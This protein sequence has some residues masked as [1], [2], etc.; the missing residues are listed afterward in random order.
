MSNP[1]SHLV[2]HF[3]SQLQHKRDTTEA[4]LEQMHAQTVQQIQ[5]ALDRLYFEI[6]AKMRELAATQEDGEPAKIPLSWLHEDNRLEQIKQYVTWEVDNFATFARITAMQAVDWATGL[7]RQ[8]ADSFMRVV[9]DGLLPLIKPFLPNAANKLR[10]LFSS[11]GKDAA[12][13]LG[14]ALMLGLSLGQKPA[15]M[16]AQITKVLDEPRWRA[17][18]IMETE[19]QRVFVDVLLDNYQSN[20]QAITGWIWNCRLSARSCAACIFL[21]GT[22]HKLTE[23]LDDHPR[24]QC[25][26]TPYIASMNDIQRGVDWFEE[27]DESVKRDILG[28]DAAWDLYRAGTSLEAF[29][30]TR[31]DHG[32]APMV[33]QRSVKQITG[34]R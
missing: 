23:T 20:A 14:D 34:A 16:A 4:T 6:N 26:P 9:Q 21:H 19:T 8:T 24:G 1:L 33:Y 22:I 30:G 28:T 32:Y 2:T 7:G 5:P 12:K 10:D 11:F 27:Q 13:G 3:R 31:H 25:F 17:V 29:V 18:T 15:E